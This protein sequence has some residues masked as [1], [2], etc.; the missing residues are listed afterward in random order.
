MD[1]LLVELFF[2]IALYC[3]SPCDTRVFWS[4]CRKAF[5][6]V[7]HRPAR[8]VNRRY[9]G[10]LY[11]AMNDLPALFDGHTTYLLRILHIPCDK[12]LLDFA[13]KTG[14]VYAMRVLGMQLE[15]SAMVNIGNEVGQQMLHQMVIQQ[16]VSIAALLINKFG[17]NIDTQDLY[18]WT[19]LHQAVVV[20]DPCC[21]ELLLQ[22][23]NI[24]VNVRNICG[25]SVLHM[26]IAAGQTEQVCQL[27]A[28]PDI[29]INTVNYLE[30]AVSTACRKPNCVQV[31]QFSNLLI[32]TNI[33]I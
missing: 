28:Y 30:A 29:N 25:Y 13:I 18:G 10:A 9:S 11:H 1:T 32:S 4:T 7:H 24:D 2:E 20:N 22:S 14:N 31:G 15:L 27:C 26:A 6:A 21:S 19:A 5:C 8:Y 17:A 16:N 33:Y 3:T 23:L 12:T